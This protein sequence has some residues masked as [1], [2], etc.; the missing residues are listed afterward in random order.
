MTSET[1]HPWARGR[2]VGAAMV[3]IGASM[4]LTIV[5]G[6]LGPSAMVPALGGPGWQPPYSLDA[7][8]DP[9]LVVGLAGAAIVLGGV[10]LLGALAGVR[11]PSDRSGGL[12]GPAVGAGIC[13]LYTS[14]AADDLTR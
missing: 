13:L 4:L 7:G 2:L 8:P 6:L 3:A 9:Y 5:I 14:D 12:P 1:R 11:D 10:G